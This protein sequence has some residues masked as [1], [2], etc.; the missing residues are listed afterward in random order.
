MGRL[1]LLKKLYGK[2]VIQHGVWDEVVTEAQG[3]PGA[4][5]LETGVNEGWIKVEK[6]N[7]S[8]TSTG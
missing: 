5:G 8:E 6:M 3:R 1:D 2:I 4:S 7:T